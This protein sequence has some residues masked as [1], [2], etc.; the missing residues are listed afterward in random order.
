MARLKTANSCCLSRQRKGDDLSGRR[1]LVSGQKHFG[2]G[3]GDR[4]GNVA[5]AT[6]FD[7]VQE[8]TDM[9]EDELTQVIRAVSLPFVRDEVEDRLEYLDREPLERLAYLARRRCRNQGY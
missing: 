5:L 1:R 3:G 4:C 6:L 2:R 9:S 8:V 7:A